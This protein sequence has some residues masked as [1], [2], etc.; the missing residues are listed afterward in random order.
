MSASRTFAQRTF[1]A[2]K[3]ASRSAAQYTSRSSPSVSPS[4]GS[5]ASSFAASGSNPILSAWRSE[6]AKFSANNAS[7][8]SWGFA[9]PAQPLGG[10]SN[11]QP[12]A[13]QATQVH[14]VSTTAASGAVSEEGGDDD[15]TNGHTSR[16]SSKSSSVGGGDDDDDTL[17]RRM[18]GVRKKT[19]FRPGRGDDSGGVP[20]VKWTKQ[21]RDLQEATNMDSADPLE[22]RLAAQENFLKKPKEMVPIPDP[23]RQVLFSHA[24]DKVL[25]D[26]RR[27]VVIKQRGREEVYTAMVAVG[28][29]RGLLGLG[30][31]DASTA[32]DAVAQ[33][34]MACYSNLTYVPLYRGHTI[35][36]DIQ[37]KYHQFKMHLMPRHD[38]WGVKSSDLIAELCGLVGIKN[39]SVKLIGRSK[40]KFYVAECLKEALAMQTVPHDGVE[41]T[42]VYVKEVFKRGG[43]VMS[44]PLSVPLYCQQ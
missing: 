28:N 19:V 24:W 29:K 5:K 33:A 6:Q 44:L 40:N 18:R 10:M 15:T 41:G 39:I 20:F 30:L 17:S 32:Q 3:E 21:Q 14:N 36:H 31:K 4:L 35:F 8:L 42:G 11:A 7:G 2:L 43:K 25:V 37:H 16:F 9:A 12:P 27:T 26:V 34:H 22:F 13:F 1:A 38:G 23:I